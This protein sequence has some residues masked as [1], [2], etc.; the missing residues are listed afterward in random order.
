MEPSTA[1]EETGAPQH[2]STASFE[3][4]YGERRRERAYSPFAPLLLLFV[5][6]A[7]WS[8]FQC[9]QLVTEKQAIAT[10]VGNQSKQFD[11]AGK[12]RASLEALARDT[13]LLAGQGHAGAKA[14]V[15]ELA[16]RGVRIDPNAAPSA[17]PGA[18]K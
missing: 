1:T 9:Y 8:A 17:P 11:E 5:A 15:D 14:I 13:A 18:P 6:V 12:L 2:A 3:D 10:V 16:R 4:D 7:A